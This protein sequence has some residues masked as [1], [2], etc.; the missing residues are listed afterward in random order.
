MSLWEYANPRRFLGLSE[1]LLPGL[2]ALALLLLTGGLI[3]GFFYSPDD[4]RMGS[5][6]K[7]IYLHV[8]SA[9]M[10]INGWIMMLAASLVWLIRR[11]HVSALAAKAAA[12]VGAVMTVI[13]LITGAIWGQP[14]W[15]TWWVWDARLTSMLILFF[16]YL[17]FIAVAN[18]FDR[19][20]RGSRPAA[21]LALVGMINVPIVKFSVDWWNTLHQPASLLRSGGPA[22]DSSMLTP[23]VLTL[24]AAHAYFAI[25]VI[26]RIRALL[27]ER[28]LA[29]LMLRPGGD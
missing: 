11:H 5:T 8:P 7:I 22:I 16:F 23:L 15:G 9:L 10:A 19:A 20:E 17:G 21:L 13:A 4:Y 25:L 27:T 28:R 6:V 29:A 26:L 3:W 18:G 12:P 1:R 2:S 14:M 24:I